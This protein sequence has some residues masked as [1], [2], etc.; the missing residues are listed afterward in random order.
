MLDYAGKT[1]VKSELAPRVTFQNQDV[2]DLPFA[3]D[4]FDWVWSADCVGYAPQVHFSAMKELQRVVRPGGVT[5]ILFWSSQL[6]PGYP[7]LEARLNATTQ[8]IAPFKRHLSP[9][10]HPL[11]AAGRFRKADL[12]N[13]KARTFIGDVY[14][15]LRKE[16]RES[17]ISLIRMRWGEAA[18]SE[19][20]R[21]SRALYERLCHP[22][23]PDFIIDCPDY[24]AF[25]TYSLFTGEIS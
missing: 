4:T 17:L 10:S 13:I 22:E 1:A 9:N 18:I 25:F 21:G 24:Y 8:G 16:I 3:D 20:D 14:A 7:E 2:N 15:P 6:L 11:R 5:A 19:L 23:S 12:S